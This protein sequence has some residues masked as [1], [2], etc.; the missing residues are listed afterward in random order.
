MFAEGSFG[1]IPD[2][3]RTIRVEYFVTSGSQGKAEAGS[4]DSISDNI[5]FTNPD[6]PLD[7]ILGQ[8]T[9][10]QE[11]ESSE[12]INI[13][14]LDKIKKFAPLYFGIQNRL[15]NH[16]DY[17][18]Y[19]LGEYPYITD[20][21]AFNYEEAVEAKLLRSPCENNLVNERWASYTNQDVI[22]Y[23]DPIKVPT[24]WDLKGFYEVYTV[25]D[26]DILPVP[27][28]NEEDVDAGNLLNFGTATGLFVDA[29]RPCDD[30]RGA[31]IGQ[32]TD[33]L[34]TDD[35]CTVVHFEVEVMNPNWNVQTES[36]PVIT[37]DDLTLF[38]N[39][40][41]LFTRID[42]FIYNTNGYLS[43]ICCCD[44]EGDVRG[45][46]TIKGVYLLDA[47]TIDPDDFSASVLGTIFVKPNAQLLI[48]EAKIYPAT[49]LTSNDVF[50]VPVPEVGGYLNIETKE[51]I[52][53]DLDQIKMITVRNHIV[54]PI[55]QTFDIRVVFKRDETSLLTLE[56][57]ANTIKTEIV[58]LFLPKNQKL[59]ARLNTLDV[60]NIIND[61]PGVARARVVLEPRSADLQ[62]RTNE[63]GDYVLTDAEFP[64]LGRIQLG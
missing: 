22:G 58:T 37:K 32:R 52:L 27:Q 51:D 35:C 60:A 8:Y 16:F 61:L 9:I 30:N 40:E 15:G 25:I 5:Y 55:Y 45:W 43:N 44:R 21:N 34:T 64:I 49:C 48:G 7:R 53:A 26:G 42:P 36:Y 24:D 57:V 12:G 28:V 63:L 2:A 20:A 18:W 47:E 56:D 19:V 54:A 41:E 33:V 17:K 11:L 59:G 38:I 29:T 14:P 3:G 23:E 46:Y 13:E 1:K 50:V 39:G 6:N 10:T 4:I 31:T 62:A